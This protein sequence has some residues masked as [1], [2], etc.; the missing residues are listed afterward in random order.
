MSLSDAPTDVPASSTLPFDPKKVGPFDVARMALSRTRAFVVENLLVLG[1]S[2]VVLVVAAW[3]FEVQVP[4]VPNWILVGVLASTLAAPSAWFVGR[5]LAR[6]LYQPDDELLSIVD[7]STGD[8]ELVRVAPDRFAEMTVLNHNDKRRDRGFLHVVSVNGR[9]AYEV[10]S[11]DPAENVAVASW[12]AGVSNAE[13]RRDR[14]AIKRIKTSLE[15][16]ADK[17]LELLA[18]HPNILRE[19]A[20]EVSN[21]VIKVAEGVEVPQ[22][23]ELHSRLGRLLD[24][25]DPS[26]DLLADDGDDEEDSTDGAVDLDPD[27]EELLGI[28]GR[29][30]RAA[31]NGKAEAPAD[32]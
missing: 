22:G 25:A 1:A 4:R 6:A 26:D 16:E 24:E 14:S 29:A 31:T 19:Q 2:T 23:G 5:W 8:Q 9:R 27:D 30:A 21:R 10:D 7:P 13:I 11:Y 3:Y 28:F 15:R 12:Q 32:D 20:R 17:S 18:N